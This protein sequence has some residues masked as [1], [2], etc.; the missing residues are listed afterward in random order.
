MRAILKNTNV[1]ENKCVRDHY[2]SY[3]CTVH[4]KSKVK[5]MCQC[6]N[7][8]VQWLKMIMVHTCYKA[9]QHP[10]CMAGEWTIYL[11]EEEL[12]APRPSCLRMGVEGCGVEL[13]LI[14]DYLLHYSSTASVKQPWIK[15]A[16]LRQILGSSAVLN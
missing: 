16:S 6:G 13:S 11:G 10:G 1:K 4:T 9:W 14:E 8:E 3:H 12:C 15:K 7:I 5:K 2:H